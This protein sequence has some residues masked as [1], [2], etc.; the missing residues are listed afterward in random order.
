[1]PKKKAGGR[2]RDNEADLAEL[3]RLRK[4]VAEQS[5]ALKAEEDR[6]EEESKDKP[7]VNSRRQRTLVRW[8]VDTD[9]RL[10][11]AMQ[12]VCNR[13]SIKVPWKEI[14][15]TMGE[16]FTEGAIVQHLSKLRVK[17]EEQ[18]KPI[19]PPLK[20]AGNGSK[21]DA[22]PKE[23]ARKSRSNKRRR[24][25]VSDTESEASVYTLKKKPFAKDK[26]KDKIFVAPKLRTKRQDTDS[27]GSQKLTCVGS[28]WISDFE[29]GDEREVDEESD[30]SEATS[31]ESSQATTQATNKSKMVTLK[32]S[33]QRLASVDHHLGN[34]AAFREPV[35]PTNPSRVITNMAPRRPSYYPIMR[36][37]SLAPLPPLSP[38]PFSNTRPAIAFPSNGSS[39]F[40]IINRAPG[41]TSEAVPGVTYSPF[42]AEMQFPDQYHGQ[43]ILY[44]ETSGFE[45][46]FIPND[47]MF[48]SLPDVEPPRYLGYDGEDVKE[49]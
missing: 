21:K 48:V 38:C 11:L 31:T 40:D 34:S 33:S 47:E 36:S 3:E 7:Q 4:Q 12:Y 29:K 13:N 18:A 43:G 19:P 6:K 23:G 28:E 24:R 10:L 27:L 8:D 45:N 14:A 17:R 2:K 41:G 46:Q 37:D 42:A 25:D 9:I 1:M 15:E 35:T 22:S 49:F 5:K 30:T 44:P 16:K 26:K 32:V 20:R 39:P